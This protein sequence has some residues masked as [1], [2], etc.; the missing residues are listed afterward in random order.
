MIIVVFLLLAWYRHAD[1]CDDLTAYAAL[2][3]FFSAGSFE[4]EAR[5]KQLKN[6]EI[7]RLTTEIVTIKRYYSNNVGIS[8]EMV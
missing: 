8:I 6:A 7:K 2:C 4:Q 3:W 1:S 5:S